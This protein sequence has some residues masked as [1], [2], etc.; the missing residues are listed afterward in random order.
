MN[1][2]LVELEGGNVVV[3]GHYGRPL[4]AFPSEQGRADQY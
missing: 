4:L 3:H 1:G 2:R